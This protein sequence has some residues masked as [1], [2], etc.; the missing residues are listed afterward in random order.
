M[1]FSKARWM[2]IVLAGIALLGLVV[3]QAYA[4]VC[5]NGSTTDCNPDGATLNADARFVDPD[6]PSGF[7]QCA[8]F[9]N[10]AADDVA[11]NWENN[12]LDAKEGP[13]FMRLFNAETGELLA[14]ARLFGPVTACWEGATAL[15]YRTDQ[16]EGEGFR[17]NPNNSCGLPDG[18]TLA[19]MTSDRSYCGCSR[20]GGGTGTCNDIFTANAANTK[21]LYVGGNSSNHNYE[22]VWGPPGP[23]N[24]CSL[25]SEI[26]RLSVAIYLEAPDTDGDGINDSED[27]C[28]QTENEDQADQDEDGVGDVC[29]NCPRVSN[30]DQSDRDIDGVGDAC[31]CAPDDN[32]EPGE[33]GICPPTCTGGPAEMIQGTQHLVPSTFSLLLLTLFVPFLLRRRNDSA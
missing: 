15:T 14:G 20:P 19:W 18:V 24:T 11:W 2:T 23:K 3:P 33:D 25:N 5:S 6:P 10:T 27:N 31:D 7:Q 29:D 1:R 26:V 30:D 8:G 13:L 4:A 9:T 28:P 32:A 22:A 16:H 12:C 21:I 17:D